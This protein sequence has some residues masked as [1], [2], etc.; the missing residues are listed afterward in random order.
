VTKYALDTNLYIRA[1][2]D[3]AHG[4]RL[5]E[6]FASNSYRCYLSMVVLHELLVGART[7][8]KAA[9]IHRDVARPFDRTA[10]TFFPSGAAWTRAGEAIATL[11]RTQGL[12]TRSMPRSMVN[13]VLIAASCRENG[14][15][16]ITE[17]TADF[18][19]ICKVV[20]VEFAPP[21]P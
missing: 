21:W 3:S 11:S 8:A 16:L 17:N 15:T 19:R 5:E 6:F 12:D 4:V 20:P 7:P 2:R 10:R 18:E 9:E 13:D 14:I 1:F